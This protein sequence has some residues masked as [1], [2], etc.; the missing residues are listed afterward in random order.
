M[1]KYGQKKRVY[2]YSMGQVL[3]L[4]VMVTTCSIIQ[5]STNSAMSFTRPEIGFSS[6]SPAEGGGGE[7]EDE[8][9]FDKENFDTFVSC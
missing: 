1:D 8:W 4:V 7:G 2:Y 9:S 5:A 6:F 3:R